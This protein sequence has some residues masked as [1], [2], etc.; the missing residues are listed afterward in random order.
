MQNEITARGALLGSDG[1]LNQRGYAKRP[2]LTYNP[3]NVGVTRVPLLKRLRLKEWDYYG[4]TTADCF[5]SA[6]VSHVGYIGL[7]FVY[8][9]DFRERSCLFKSLPTPF[10]MG[11]RMPRSS[12]RGDVSF[13]MRGV[14]IRFVRERER[15]LLTVEW[16]R[17]HRGADLAAELVA[18]QPEGMDSIV[19]ATPMGKNHFYYNQKINCMPTSGWVRCGPIARDLSEDM[20]LTTLDWGRGVWPYRTFWNWGSASGFLKDGRTVGLN[21]GCGFG[22]LSAA[23]ENC[24]FVNGKMSKLGSVDFDYD[25]SD[26]LQ[27]WRFRSDDDRLELTLTPV[28]DRA[29]KMN[30]LAV[31]TEGHQ[32]FGRY[33]GRIVT[34]GGETIRIENLMGWAE[35]HRA[36]W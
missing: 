23:T 34:D 19:M 27:P 32:M 13:G 31:S 3:E 24:V 9:I 15:R 28:Y 17:F 20:A 16:K 26:Y 12:E 14:R 10:G 1:R 18:R 11:C 25:P 4:V 30:L 33:D 22:D 2:V 35:E 7:V 8:Y 36:R 29:Q 6:T 21:L 5:F